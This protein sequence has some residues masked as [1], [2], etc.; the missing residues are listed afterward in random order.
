MTESST[1]A[2]NDL[3]FSFNNSSLDQD[4]KDANSSSTFLP[5][6]ASS[7]AAS[8]SPD[9]STSM[10]PNTTLS[11][12]PPDNVSTSVHP[13]SPYFPRDF[14]Q[15]ARLNRQPDGIR[16]KQ[17]YHTAIEILEDLVQLVVCFS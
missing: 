16:T 1:T 2:Y 8:P 10:S 5:I 3:S 6:T 11:T 4:I 15:P 9:S 17:P 7:A 14:P 13:L 12:T